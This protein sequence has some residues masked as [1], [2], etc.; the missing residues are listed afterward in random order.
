MLGMLVPLAVKPY[1]NDPAAHFE[2]L[3]SA[4]VKVILLRQVIH[5]FDM[6]GTDNI[7]KVFFHDSILPERFLIIG[8]HTTN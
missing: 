2:K 7:R 8:F 3:L 5:P 1:L 4:L 6:R